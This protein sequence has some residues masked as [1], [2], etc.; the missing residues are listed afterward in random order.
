MSDDSIT[1]KKNILMPKY[2]W[3]WLK[4]NSEYYGQTKYCGLIRQI[5]IL[6]RIHGH[7]RT[8]LKVPGVDK[9]EERKPTTVIRRRK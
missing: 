1:V 2:L 7:Y 4:D 6:E 3:E 5:I 8:M 9:K